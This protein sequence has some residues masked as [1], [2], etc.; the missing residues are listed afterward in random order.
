[1]Q[2]KGEL[3]NYHYNGN[4]S[5]GNTLYWLAATQQHLLLPEQNI[6]IITDDDN[7]VALP[8]VRAP[9]DSSIWF[10]PSVNVYT[11][12]TSI[13]F[14]NINVDICQSMQ[15]L[16]KKLARRKDWSRIKFGPVDDASEL[17]HTLTQQ[18]PLHAV[19]SKKENWYLDNITDF[20][21]YY[22]ARPSKLKNTIKRKSSALGKKYHWNIVFVTSLESF[23]QC[24]NDYKKVYERSWKGEE[25]NYQF[26]YQ[27]CLSALNENALRMAV[28]YVENQPAAAQVWFNYQGNVSIFKLAYDEA[29]KKYSV[30]SILSKAVFKWVIEQDRPN[31]IEFGV[32]S[33]S[34]KKDWMTDCRYLVTLD[35]YNSNT[36]RG[37]FAY[38]LKAFKRWIK[39]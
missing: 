18:L 35:L 31:E 7:S 27:V 23:K 34:Y 32:G 13:F 28:L 19:F 25:T 36:F 9:D 24:F 22:H 20:D 10:T 39:C 3:N 17:Y 1:M 33:E 11:T 16:F 29:Y 15:A 14:N 38:S 5:C 2:W 21:S 4:V 8:I 6:E 30:G 12:T 26:I 37:K